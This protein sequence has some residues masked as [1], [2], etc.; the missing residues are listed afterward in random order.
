MRILIASKRAPDRPG[1]RNGGV[2][3]WVKTVA[4][5]LRRMG[6]S[7]L[8]VDQLRNDLGERYDF[9]IL[10]NWQHV[11]HFAANCERYV[12][13]CHGIVNDE[14]PPEKGT[15][16]YTSEEV[17]KHWSHDEES[18]IRQP[19]DLDFWKPGDEPRGPHV[20]R[21]AART[22]LHWLAAHMEWMGHPFMHLQ[23]ATHEHARVT[24]QRAKCVIAT[25]R[26]A[27]EAMACGAP[28][29]IAD[30][31]HYQGPLIDFDTLGSMRRNY[32]GRGGE[33]PTPEKMSTAI[34]QAIS[35]GSLREHVAKHHDV[36]SVVSQLLTL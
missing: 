12:V 15:V 21:Y 13:M 36:K 32:S 9:G 19:I 4:A 10:N 18:I 26:C 7:V 1:R 30:D 11:G 20:V 23:Q 24:L 28:V 22:G 33:I 3:T 16:A 6:H 17:R 29:V 35:R 5:E 31:R 34:V 2:Q 8:I 14:H 27:V 25:G